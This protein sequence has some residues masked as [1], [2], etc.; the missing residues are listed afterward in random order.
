MH[1]KS[2][3]PSAAVGGAIS[4]RMTR[5]HFLEFGIAASTLPFVLS[6]QP[7]AAE[8]ISVGLSLPEFARAGVEKVAASVA[9][10]VVREQFPNLFRRLDPTYQVGEATE[11]QLSSFGA[12]LLNHSQMYA[13][14][15]GQTS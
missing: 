9:A 11:G 14:G 12:T 13:K 15:V 6:A 5:R 8:P 3:E 7:A 2:L 4:K 1:P 10:D